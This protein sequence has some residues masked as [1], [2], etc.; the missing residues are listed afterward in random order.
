M[1]AAQQTRKTILIVEDEVDLAGLIRLNLEREGYTCRVAHAGD[2][3]LQ[4]VARETPDLVLLDRMLPGMSG[5][6]VGAQLRKNVATASIPIVMLTAKTEESDELVGFAIGADDYITKPFSMK[7]LPARVAAVFRR[8]RNRGEDESETIA[9]GPFEMTPSHHKL[10]VDGNAVSLTATE[11]KLLRELMLAKGR[12]LDRVRL[13]N[14]VLGSDAVVTDRTI[15]VHI[16]AL[17]KKIGAASS[18]V[19]TVR[20]VGYT[21]RPPEESTAAKP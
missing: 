1:I 2:E 21:F 14:R 9:T 8:A 17:R 6:E 18:W 7:V 16:T 20:G 13:I 11:F 10:I 4:A 5:D 19:Q 3:A 15:D 12:V